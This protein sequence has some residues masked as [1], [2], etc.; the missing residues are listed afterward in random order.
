[1]FFCDSIY[2]VTVSSRIDQLKSCP[3]LFPVRPLL[4]EHSSLPDIEVVQTYCTVHTKM[5]LAST[6]LLFCTFC[7]I[8]VCVSEFH[9]VEVQPGEQVTLMCSNFSSFTGHMSW[10][11]LD[12]RPNISRIASMWSSDSNVSFYDGFKN[13]KF[14]MTSNTTTLFLNID[15]VGLA[16][17]GL[18]FCGF[19]SNGKPV[20]ATAT[21]LKVQEVFDGIKSPTIVILLGLILFLVTV[22]IG[23][24]VKIS[25]LCT[26]LKEGQTPQRSENLGSDALNYASFSF[27]PKARSS[28]R[29]ESENQLEPNV[30]YAATR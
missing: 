1:M 17:S 24:V 11:R 21:Y 2:I 3:P 10:F 14:N 16:D 23:L 30:V 25:R 5:K 27:Y 19:Y 22:V 13:G 15:H 12:S 7:L 29:P 8:S 28:R 9:T 26:A 18:Y 4:L 6:T 20:I